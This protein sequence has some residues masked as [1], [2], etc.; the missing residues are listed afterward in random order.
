M[1]ARIANRVQ[2]VERR[3][4]DSDPDRCDCHHYELEYPGEG[5]INPAPAT[6]PHGRP[7]PHLTRIAVVYDDRRV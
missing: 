1:P 7:W 4:R 2:A 6:C 5:V 3:M